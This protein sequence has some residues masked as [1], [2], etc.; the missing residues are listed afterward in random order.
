MPKFFVC[1]YFLCLCVVMDGSEGLA[2]V[3]SA[4]VGADESSIE[5][6]HAVLV[7][8]KDEEDEDEFHDAESPQSPNSLDEVVL[9]AEMAQPLHD[10][11]GWVPGDVGGEMS[12]FLDHQAVE[13]AIMSGEQAEQLPKRSVK[14][15]DDGSLVNEFPNERLW[16]SG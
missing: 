10:Q 2:D 5:D 3:E 4:S 15:K 6:C 1:V 11:A 12:M 9:S 8:F 13:D 7:T 14:F 16:P